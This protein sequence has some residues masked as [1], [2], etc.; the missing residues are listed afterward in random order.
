MS[1]VRVLKDLYLSDQPQLY[2]SW[3]LT[4]V[5]GPAHPLAR[6]LLGCRVQL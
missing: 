4:L 1:D 5:I 6:M 2:F 3:V